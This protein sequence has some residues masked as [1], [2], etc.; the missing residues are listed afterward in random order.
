VATLLVAS[1]SPGSRSETGFADRGQEARHARIHDRE[2]D[3]VQCPAGAVRHLAHRRQRQAEAGVRAA[4]GHRVVETRVRARERA[5][6][7]RD[8]RAVAGSRPGRQRREHL[9][10]ARGLCEQTTQS[11]SEAAGDIRAG[12][13]RFDRGIRGEEGQPDGSRFRCEIAEDAVERIAAVPVS[14]MRL[15]V[16]RPLA[17]GEAVDHVQ[18]EQ[19]TRPVEHALV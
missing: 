9:A 12:R 10:Q 13:R 16:Q 8:G 1:R 19:R 4:G 14:V 18:A 7:R 2:H 6:A 11:T 15:Q 17:G 5:V 3:I